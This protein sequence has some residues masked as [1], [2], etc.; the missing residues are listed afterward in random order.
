[1]TAQIEQ[2]NADEETD[3]IRWET[4]V[5]KAACGKH[6]P[7]TLLRVGLTCRYRRSTW[8]RV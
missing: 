2:E 4:A 8:K 6:A 1:L 5:W 3:V 7:T